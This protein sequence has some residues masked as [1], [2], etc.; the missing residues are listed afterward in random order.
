MVRSPGIL[1]SRSI[2]GADVGSRTSSTSASAE[3]LDLL[4]GMPTVCSRFPL[5]ELELFALPVGRP[6]DLEVEVEADEPSFERFLYG[7]KRARN[8]SMAAAEQDL[9]IRSQRDQG[10]DGDKEMQE[11]R[12]VRWTDR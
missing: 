2:L 4:R 3:K 11:S 10:C 8:F 12:K 1:K 9:S 7:L 5:N 6:A